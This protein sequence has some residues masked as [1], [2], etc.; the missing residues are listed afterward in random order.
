MYRRAVQV[1]LAE[2]GCLTLRADV[3]EDLVIDAGGRLAGVVCASG[4]RIGCGAAVL[5]TGTFLRGMIHVGMRQTPAG[6]VGEAPSVALA[7]TLLRLGLPMGRLKTGTPPRL[8]RDSI[9]W[10]TL[11]ADRGMRSPSRSAL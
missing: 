4:R 1:A 3:A 11:M 9:D 8:A 5:T 10:E 2:T 7:E 6:R